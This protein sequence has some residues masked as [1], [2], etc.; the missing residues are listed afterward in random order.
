MANAFQLNVSTVVAGLGT[1]T[2]TVPA[3]TATQLYT[4]AVNF[5]IPYIASGSS[6]NSTVTTGGSGL[7]IVV[8]NNGSPILTVGGTATNPTPTQPSISGSVRATLAA[9]D[10]VTVVLSSSNAVDSLANAVKGTINFYAGT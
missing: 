3:G 2:Y 10:V 9:A 6:S 7:Q 5:T 4:I 8:N 1:Q